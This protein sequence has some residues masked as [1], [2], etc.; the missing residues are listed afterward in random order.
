MPAVSS[1]KSAAASR[2]ATILPHVLKVI[3]FRVRSAGCIA[4]ALDSNALQHFERALQ[5]NIH[6]IVK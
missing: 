5:L 3:S 4:L 6:K 2:I 1:Q